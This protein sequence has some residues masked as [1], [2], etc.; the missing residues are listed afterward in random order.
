MG[1]GDEI[2]A[3]AQA[4]EVHRAT[5][6]KTFFGE[7]TKIWLNNPYIAKNHSKAVQV[8]NMTGDR[9]YVLNQ[10][11]DTVIFNPNFRAVPGELY[12]TE[13]EQ[14]AAKAACKGLHDFIILEPNTK[15]TFSK[16]NKKWSWGRWQQLAD[17]L[18]EDYTVAQF[19]YGERMLDGVKQI[20][21]KTFRTGCACLELCDLFIGSEGG[22]H[23]A[24]AALGTKAV[25][26]WSGYSHPLQLGYADHF[27]L[28]ADNSPPCGKKVACNHCK[29]MMERITVEQVEEAVS[30]LLG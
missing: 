23:H 4:R 30:T 5:G 18:R 14:K 3:T 28:R 9:P 8:R 22:L 25:V 21:A 20:K 24:C 29:D 17:R 15:D 10:T 11:P 7:W 27:N 12:F 16:G 6:Y 1:Y 19:D 2:M 13:D 26:L